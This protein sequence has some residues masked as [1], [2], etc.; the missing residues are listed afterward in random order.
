MQNINKKL[1]ITTLG[2]VEVF[3]LLA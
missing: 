2:A 3:R 1:Y